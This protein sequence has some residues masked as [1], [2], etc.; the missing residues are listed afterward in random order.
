MMPSRESLALHH[1]DLLGRPYADQLAHQAAA[2]E[3][4]QRQMLMER[5]R[6]SHPMHAH[7]EYLR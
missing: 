7:E 2:H 3:Q 4:L 5:D 6:F 1:P